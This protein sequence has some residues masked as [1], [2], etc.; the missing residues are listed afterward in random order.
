MSNTNAYTSD[1]FWKIYDIA[2]GIAFDKYYPKEEYIELPDGTIKKYKGDIL[3]TFDRKY[4]NKIN[5]TFN[6]AKA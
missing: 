5:R 1:L 6:D 4:I 3:A 2:I